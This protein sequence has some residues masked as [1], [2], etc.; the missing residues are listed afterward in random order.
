MDD[1]AQSTR[2]QPAGLIYRTR[3]LTLQEVHHQL[4]HLSVRVLRWMIDRGEI[5]AVRVGGGRGRAYVP[6]TEIAR[7]Q[8]DRIGTSQPGD[9]QRR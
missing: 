2:Q 3:L 8:R 7:L 5:R 4:P 6:A 1:R 9:E